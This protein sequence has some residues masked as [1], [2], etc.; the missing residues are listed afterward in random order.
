MKRGLI[1]TG[2]LGVVVASTRYTHRSHNLAICFVRLIR[3]INTSIA[4]V[5]FGT[6]NSASRTG[7]KAVATLQV[8]LFAVE[9]VRAVGAV[10][11]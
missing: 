7:F 10:V 11:V 1:R 5:G 6:A 8:R 2:V 4:E 3:T 9:L